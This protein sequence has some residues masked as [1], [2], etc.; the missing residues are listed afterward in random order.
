VAQRLAEFF[1]GPNP[2]GADHVQDL[3]LAVALV[4]G[5]PVMLARRS[6]AERRAAAT[7]AGPVPPRI[8]RVFIP[9][10]GFISAIIS[11]LNAGSNCTRASAVQ[12][13]GFLPA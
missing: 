9:S 12:S 4:H 11:G 13:A 6:R 3:A 8:S 1:L 10:D 5:Y 2:A 7:A